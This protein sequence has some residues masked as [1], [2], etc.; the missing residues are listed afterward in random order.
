M[1]Y[2]IIESLTGIGILHEA[3]ADPDR[4]GIPSSEQKRRSRNRRGPAIHL[5]AEDLGFNARQRVGKLRARID[6]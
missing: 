4:I 3:I 5:L 6:Q 2:Y 1:G